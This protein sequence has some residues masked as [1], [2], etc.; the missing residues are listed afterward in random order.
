MQSEVKY[1]RFAETGV[2]VRDVDLEDFIRLYVN[3][4]PVVDSSREELQHAFAVLGRL[5][6]D[7][8]RVISR[9][10]MLRLLQTRGEPMTEEELAE[11]FTILL[12]ANPEGGTPELEAFDSRDSKGLLERMLPEEVS[13]ETFMVDI[14][15]WSASARKPSSGAAPPAEPEAP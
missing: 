2:E 1:S 7:G 15:G 13:L 14:L 4:R 8:E 12:G 5:T 6:E 9:D 3:H 11:C 10:D